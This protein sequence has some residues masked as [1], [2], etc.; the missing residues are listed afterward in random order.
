MSPSTVLIIDDDPGLCALAATLVTRLGFQPLE[1]HSGA[2]A[3][4][5][6]AAITPDLIILDLAMPDMAGPEVLA[7]LQRMPHLAAT[8]IL[9]WTARPNMLVEMQAASY[10]CLV[11]KPV[12]A[13]EFQ[14]VLQ[15]MLAK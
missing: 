11:L 5:L 15:D 10:D 6:A 3:L 1:S 13:R 7:H 14:A 4:R 12:S 2:E 9:V 8:K